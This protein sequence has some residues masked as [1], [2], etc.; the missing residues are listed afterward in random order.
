MKHD[1]SS[2]AA[3]NAPFQSVYDAKA[4]GKRIRR[5]R[6]MRGLTQEDAAE[7]VGRSLRFYAD[8]ERGACGMSVATLLKISAIYETTPDS[9]LLAQE[10][11]LN[12]SY[13][14]K[15]IERLSALDERQKK[16]ALMLLE[17]FLE[18]ASASD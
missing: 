7:L 10:P 6:E 5:Q 13:Q 14:H 15:L 8:I 17:L 3:K 12:E 9:L 11:I 18:A 4:V 2:P 1:Q 16:Y